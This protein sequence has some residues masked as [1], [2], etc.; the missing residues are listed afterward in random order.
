MEPSGGGGNDDPP[1]PRITGAAHR[2]PLPNPVDAQSS[3]VLKETR[4]D[5]EKCVW[6]WKWRWGGGVQCVFLRNYNL[7][8]NI[9]TLRHYHSHAG[10]CRRLAVVFLRAS[11]CSAAKAVLIKHDAHF[12][13]AKC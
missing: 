11:H 6:G 7:L 5:V 4:M 10:P 9:I 12:A 1:R 3:E 8:A 13:A 2:G